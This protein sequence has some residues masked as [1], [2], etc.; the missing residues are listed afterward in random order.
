VGAPLPRR[1][2]LEGSQ[3]VTR[4]DPGR[5]RQTGG[6][7]TALVVLTIAAAFPGRSP[8]RADDPRP[9]VIVI[10]TDDQSF[11]TLPSHPPAMP[12][13]QAQI[14]DP[15]GNWRWFPNA[16]LNTPLCCPSRASLL[17]GLYS[18]HTGVQDNGDGR[19]LDERTT[20]AL[21]LHDAGYRTALIGKYLN[22]YPFGRGPYVPVGWDRWVGK[23]NL[24]DATTYYG[25]PFVD[26]GVPLTGGLA[27]DAYATD[28]L[29]REAA[30]F[31]RSAPAGQ[32]Y[33]LL[34]TPS[35]PHGPQTPPPR[36][37]TAFAGLTLPRPP[38]FGIT[39]DGKP[40]WVRTLPPIDEVAGQALDSA[41]VRERQ[42]LLA[43]DDAV[44]RIV[45]AVAARGDLERT[46]IFF[47]T[48]NGL[49]FGEHGWTAKSC[50][51]VECV[52]TPFAV[53]VPG[54]HAGTDPSLVSNVD[55][56]PTIAG[57]AGLP[58]APADGR[59]LSALLE[60]TGPAPARDAVL[61]E[62]HGDGVV[63][64]WQGVRTADFAYIR[65]GSFEELYDL[66]GELGPADPFEMDNRVDDPAY[67]DVRM[68][69]AEL[70][71]VLA[72]AD[73]GDG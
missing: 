21:R 63:P 68:Q 36:Y 48:D 19:V 52:R 5:L 61:T 1:T 11:D 37:A 72:S 23:G 28:L 54:I 15:G 49:A 60:G 47:L 42:A 26:Q 64:A 65:T 73:P 46:V 20:L 18:H 12:W 51:Y 58:P 66:A 55:L 32:P 34:F 3:G 9:N 38:S 53:Y 31:V 2:D 70:T 39:D 27:P 59:D 24:S 45:A 13:L 69:L 6:T 25:Y 10:L 43:V 44:E 56:A 29:A 30:G 35:A 14:G 16:Y 71:T 8:D 57:L 40:P 67:V 22:R 17:T 7:L 33:F 50:P 62:Y 4:A 41:R